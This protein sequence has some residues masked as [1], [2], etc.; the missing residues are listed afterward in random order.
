M[1]K[2]VKSLL[3]Q[4]GLPNSTH[5][6]L[7]P[8]LLKPTLYQFS[9]LISSKKPQKQQTTPKQNIKNNTHKKPQNKTPTKTKSRMKQKLKQPTIP[10]P[11]PP[12][13]QYPKNHPHTNQPYF[14][15]R[16]WVK[17]VPEA[18]RVGTQQAWSTIFYNSNLVDKLNCSEM[19][20]R[21]FALYTI[22]RNTNIYL[23]SHSFG[24]SHCETSV[25]QL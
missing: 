14:P 2:T 8:C 11:T 3:L 21:I 23:S 20:L 1:N 12:K 4:V 9:S 5:C 13:Q 10:H 25:R 18:V 17:E 22:E 24:F 16:L 7:Y 6:F 19:C 15:L